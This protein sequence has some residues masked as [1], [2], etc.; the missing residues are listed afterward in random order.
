MI[1]IVGVQRNESAQ[2]EFI[3]LQNQGSLR[4][5]LRGH[6]IMSECTLDG[7]DLTKHTHLFRDDMLVQPGNFVILYTGRGESRWAKTKDQ[8]LVFY[9]YM[10][11]DEAVWEHCAGPMHV[12][13]PHHSYS[14][15]REALM[16]R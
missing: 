5:N 1:R 15:R 16:L 12:L 9:A 11:R 6:M 8:Q 2:E 10:N 14:E 7:S 13:S 3:L 4:Q